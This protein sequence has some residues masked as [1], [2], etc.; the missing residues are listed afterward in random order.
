M[1]GPRDYDAK[2]NKSEKEI[3]SDLTYVR[4]Q[5]IN[6]QM[7]EKQTQIRTDSCQMGGGP[8]YEEQYKGTKY[9]ELVM[10]M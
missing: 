4:I 9:K 7:K 6:E 8:G 10:G 2:C 3:P 5:R 1:D